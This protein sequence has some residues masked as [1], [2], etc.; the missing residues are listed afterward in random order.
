MI[1]KRKNSVTININQLI[2]GETA[3]IKKNERI[4]RIEKIRVAMAIDL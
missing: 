1:N 2:R 4:F 3:L